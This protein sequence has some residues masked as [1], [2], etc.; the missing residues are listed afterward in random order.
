MNKSQR[1]VLEAIQVD[2][3]R[4]CADY[5][6]EA[7][8]TQQDYDKGAYD[9][10]SWICRMIDEESVD[11]TMCEMRNYEWYVRWL[12]ISAWLFHPFRMFRYWLTDWQA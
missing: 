5:D 2:I 4:I 10:A 9:A 12:M 1:K 6:E 7:R 8:E 11:A 3:G